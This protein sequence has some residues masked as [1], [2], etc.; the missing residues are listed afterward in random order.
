MEEKG[1]KSICQLLPQM[2]TM[3]SLKSRSL[4]VRAGMVH[5]LLQRLAWS[6]WVKVV[7]V[8]NLLNGKQ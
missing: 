2:G 8:E 4:L 5:Q 6:D 3:L 7:K 1:V